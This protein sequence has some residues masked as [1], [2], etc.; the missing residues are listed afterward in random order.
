MNIE[1]YN[2]GVP[3]MEIVE[4]WHSLEKG[5]GWGAFIPFIGIVR[6]DG[7]IV[8]LYFEL[9]A[10]LLL[11][12]F[13]KWEN[14]PDGKIYMAHSFGEVKVTETSF[15]AGIFTPHRQEGFKYLVEFVEDFKAN[16][17]IWKYDI[18][19]GGEKI[20]REERSKKLPNAG[21]LGKE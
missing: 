5:N 7:G 19:S 14:L 15:L 1:L 13:K 21:L 11:E 6:P 2:G 9:Y 8:G 20:F 4:R 12:W 10:P 16:A 18:L 3:V 17:P